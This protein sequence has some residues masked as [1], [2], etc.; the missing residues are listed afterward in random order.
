MN[1][2]VRE[3]EKGPAVI[4]RRNSTF[5]NPWWQLTI[6]QLCTLLAQ[7]CLKHGAMSAT[8]VAPGWSWTGLTSLG[9]P[10][11]WLGIVFMVLSFPTW[12]YVL[13]QLALSV[14][15]PISQSVHVLVPLCSWLVLNEKI[16]TVRWC[17]IALVVIGL[18]LVAKPVAKIEERL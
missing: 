2:V 15:F 13:R 9:S 3:D 7:L 14:A 11:V 10:F 5:S 1:I 8:Q 17:G 12:L 4:D 16:S 6:S 18:F